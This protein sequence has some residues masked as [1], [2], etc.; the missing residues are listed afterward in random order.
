MK[1]IVDLGLKPDTTG[2]S[3]VFVEL[4][5]E[6]HRHIELQSESKKSPRRWARA[7]W[8]LVLFKKFL[9]CQHLQRR[10]LF[11]M[12]RVPGNESVHIGRTFG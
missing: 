6:G 2:L 5:R 9:R 3:R 4:V 7:N 11:E 8:L 12:P 10:L 1:S